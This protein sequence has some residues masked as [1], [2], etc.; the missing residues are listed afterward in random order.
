ML[1]ASSEPKRSRKIDHPE[2]E[3]RRMELYKTWLTGN[4]G[5]YRMPNDYL[6]LGS[7]TA[8]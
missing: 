7:G 1:A 3:D 8:R 5:P 6:I 4:I 2:N